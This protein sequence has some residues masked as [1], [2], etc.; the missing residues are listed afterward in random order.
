SREH[1]LGESQAVRRFIHE[2]TSHRLR[3]VQEQIARRRVREREA[4]KML[5]ELFG[6]SVGGCQEAS[7]SV[8]S[9]LRGRERPI[10]DR[11]G[12]ALCSPCGE[13]RPLFEWISRRKLESFLVRKRQPCVSKLT[14]TPVHPAD[15][16]QSNL[17]ALARFHVAVDLL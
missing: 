12:H 16:V 10:G 13:V 1:L 17:A 3:G 6:S 14:K 5:R 8:V 11:R 9:P 7:D 2:S 4:A 15:L